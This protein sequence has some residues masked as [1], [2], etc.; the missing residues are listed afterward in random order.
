[1]IA[2]GQNV[3]TEH[4]QARLHILEAMGPNFLEAPFGGFSGMP[5]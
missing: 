4:F 1:M 2:D 3:C 5:N